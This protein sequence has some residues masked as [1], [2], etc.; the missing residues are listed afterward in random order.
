MPELSSRLWHHSLSPGELSKTDSGMEAHG[1]QLPAT[2]I[3]FSQLVRS[4]RRDLLSSYLMDIT[5]SGASPQPDKKPFLGP[6]KLDSFASSFAPQGVYTR[7]IQTGIEAPAL[8]NA[9]CMSLHAGAQS[10]QRRTA[11]VSPV[12]VQPWKTSRFAT[13]LR[14]VNCFHENLRVTPIVGM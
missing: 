4:R 6:Q 5:T 9:S 2:A 10:R 13:A 3:G 11:G 14:R 12:R 7:G 8:P 1:S